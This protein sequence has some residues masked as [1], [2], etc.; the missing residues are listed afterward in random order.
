MKLFYKIASITAL[1]MVCLWSPLTSCRY[2]GGRRRHCGP[3][4]CCGGGQGQQYGRR[5]R[6]GIQTSKGIYCPRTGETV[7]SEAALGP[8]QFR[9]RRNR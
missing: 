1:G 7:S 5:M 8:R 3:R 6:R 9:N 2:G 4:L